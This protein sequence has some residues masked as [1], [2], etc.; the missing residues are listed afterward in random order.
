[1]C[2][3]LEDIGPNLE[4][5]ESTHQKFNELQSHGGTGVDILLLLLLIE[6]PLLP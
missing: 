2:P 3:R 6:Y 4:T 1:M 5:D